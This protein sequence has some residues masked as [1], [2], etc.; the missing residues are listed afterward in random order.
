MPD[1]RKEVNKALFTDSLGP[2]FRFQQPNQNT[3]EL[4][5]TLFKKSFLLHKESNSAE[6]FEGTACQ[7][8][9]NTLL[10]PTGGV[11]P[12]AKPLCQLLT[13]TVTWEEINSR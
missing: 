12:V 8:T 13:F 3:E 2:I 6:D 11:K 5:L 4:F 10:M 1:T 9:F 7:P